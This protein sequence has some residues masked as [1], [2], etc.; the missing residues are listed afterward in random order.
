MLKVSMA[1]IAMLAAVPAGAQ[2]FGPPAPST[3]A[4]RPPPP[5]PD[6]RL[7]PSAGNYGGADVRQ[8][9]RNGRRSGQLT[10]AQAR[11]Y[12]REAAVIDSLADRYASDGDLSD[13]EQQELTMRSTV[14]RE[15]VNNERLRGARPK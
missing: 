13:S 15:Q 6:F 4:R 5:R 3:S 7:P 14:L 11:G 12:R 2:V 10:R 9:V 8:T 1:A